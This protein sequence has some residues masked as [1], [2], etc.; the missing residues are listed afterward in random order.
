MSGNV[1]VIDGNFGNIGNFR[2][3]HQV[4]KNTIPYCIN[5]NCDQY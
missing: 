5:H 3:R 4:I 2:L 1:T